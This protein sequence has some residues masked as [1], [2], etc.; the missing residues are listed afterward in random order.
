LRQLLLQFFFHS[1]INEIQF[2]IFCWQ[3]AKAKS[4]FVISNIYGNDVD[5]DDDDDDL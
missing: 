5:Y 2:E 4:I 3:V 1:F